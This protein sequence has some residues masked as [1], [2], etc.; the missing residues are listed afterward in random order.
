MEIGLAYG[1]TGMKIRVPDHIHTRI[2]EPRY[3][4]GLP[5][6][7]KAVKEALD[8]SFHIVVTSN[9]GYPLDLNVYQ[10]VK[11]YGSADRP[12]G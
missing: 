9:S 1:K 7:E 6:Q 3:V 10:S 4:K 12:V 2:V 5:D 8:E 11:G